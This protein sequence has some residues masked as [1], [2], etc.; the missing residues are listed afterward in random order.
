V[1]YETR[2]YSEVQPGTEKYRRQRLSQTTYELNSVDAER[3]VLTSSKSTWNPRGGVIHST[4]D[5]VYKA[6]EAVLP[7]PLPGSP[8]PESIRKTTGEEILVIS[9]QTIP[10]KW[11]R[12]STV[13]D[14]DLYVKIWTSDQVPGGMVLQRSYWGGQSGRSGARRIGETIYVPVQGVEPEVTS[15]SPATELGALPKANSGTLGAAPPAESRQVA[16]PPQLPPTRSVDTGRAGAPEASAI[17][18][19]EVAQWNQRY[20]TDLLRMQRARAELAR[21]TYALRRNAPAVNVP[22]EVKE[23]SDRL[24]AESQAVSMDMIGRNYTRLA[25]NMAALES[26]LKVVEDYL[27]K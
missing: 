17:S 20:R 26:T 15:G 12:L 14:P 8:T 16:A 5:H 11:E 7:S 4:N 10:T 21:R 2:Q 23:A 18:A 19:N 27:A 6:K 13:D 24:Q 25:Q 3:A 22:Q 1:T 9:G